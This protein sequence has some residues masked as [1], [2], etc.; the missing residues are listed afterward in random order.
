MVTDA[1]GDLW[2]VIVTR[3]ASLVGQL[4]TP[5]GQLSALTVELQCYSQYDGKT[6]GDLK[7][8]LIF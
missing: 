3:A 6:L 4:R 5:W 8:N 7:F 2:D 1:D